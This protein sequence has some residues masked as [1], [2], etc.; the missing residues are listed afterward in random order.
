MFQIWVSKNGYL[1]S[2]RFTKKINTVQAF[3]TKKFASK[4]YAVYERPFV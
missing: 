1:E 3:I 4:I 2:R